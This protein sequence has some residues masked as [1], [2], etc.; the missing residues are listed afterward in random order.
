MLCFVVGCHN[1][2]S[3]KLLF[4]GNNWAQQR[5]ERQITNPYVWLACPPPPSHNAYATSFHRTKHPSTRVLPHPTWPTLHCCPVLN[6]VVRTPSCSK[7]I[8]KLDPVGLEFCLAC[9]PPP[10]TKSRTHLE[11]EHEIVKGNNKF[12]LITGEIL[13]AV[14]LG[15]FELNSSFNTLWSSLINVAWLCRLRAITHSNLWRKPGFW[16]FIPSLPQS[17][18]YHTCLHE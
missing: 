13:T 4:Y 3:S 11:T 5:L 14:A 15:P 6:Q 17:H 9:S 7:L 18:H 2:V 1:F 12:G 16:I 10:N 8:L